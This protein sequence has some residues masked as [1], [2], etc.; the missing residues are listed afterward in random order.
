MT[1]L[2]SDNIISPLGVTT[3]ENWDAVLS[4]RSAVLPRGKVF[5]VGEDFTGS[6]LDRD[7]IKSPGAGYTFFETL[8]IRSAEDAIGRAGIDPS[9]SRVTFV[10]STTKGNSDLIGSV[11][12]KEV[13][14]WY[15]ARK[16]TS[17]PSKLFPQRGADRSISPETD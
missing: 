12:D 14:L 4:G 11:P 10:V 16:I 15:S 8:M 3:M 7:T 2:L 13:M 17:Y 5:G 1:C 9:D 6:L